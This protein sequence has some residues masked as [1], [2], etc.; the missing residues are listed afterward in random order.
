MYNKELRTSKDQS[1]A[2][3][4]TIV[5]ISLIISSKHA[6]FQKWVFLHRRI[7]LRHTLDHLEENNKN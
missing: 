1:N 5:M 7:H 4:K 2:C 3:V 6:T